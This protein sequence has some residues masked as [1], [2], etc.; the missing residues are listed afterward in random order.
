MIK[1][2]SREKDID[3][4]VMGS[5]G[6]EAV[7]TSYSI[8]YTKLYEVLNDPEPINNFQTNFS[9]EIPV[10]GVQEFLTLRSSK[11]EYLSKAQE[12]AREKELVAFSVI[13]S[14]INVQTAKEF[15]SVAEKALEDAREHLRIAN[16]RYD[17]GLG[18]YSDTLRASTEVTR[19]EQQIISTRKIV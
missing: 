19:A 18:L 1:T 14:Y 15:N 9:A 3:L 4:I 8:H 10:L 17:S 6:L 11:N 5:H 2:F 16:K 7:I 13:E 12:F